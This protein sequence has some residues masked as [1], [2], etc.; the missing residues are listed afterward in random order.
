[1]VK[2]S[3]TAKW[4]EQ[5]RRE[6]R[7]QVNVMLPADAARALEELQERN[8]GASYA[9]IISRALLDLAARPGAPSAKETQA[10]LNRLEQLEGRV[11]SLEHS[12][13]PTPPASGS[14]ALSGEREMDSVM[15][16]PPE[17]NGSLEMLV[18]DYT[19]LKSDESPDITEPNLAIPPTED[20]PLWE[21]DEDAPLDLFA[22][23]DE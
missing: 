19:A 2:E 22:S 14:T 12:P 16:A 20:E 7:K 5:K 15:M 9:E 3:R 11:G 8:P 21:E 17:E 1:M 23:S 10:L 18:P 13:S 4:R 6:G